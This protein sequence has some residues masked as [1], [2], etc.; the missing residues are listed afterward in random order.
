MNR[1][2]NGRSAAAALVLALGLA[3]FA[4]SAVAQD[5][6]AMR[7]VHLM[8]K[9]ATTTGEHAAVAKQ[10]R[11]QAEQLTAKAVEHEAEVTRLM[12]SA[13]PI[14]HKWPAMAPKGIQR[15]KDQAIEARR[16]SRESQRLADHHLRMSVESL[17]SR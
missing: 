3:G 13:G 15:A 11:L 1:H 4:S 2:V 12:R 17:A 9:N 7:E 5:S 10:Y 14:V 16:A 6:P 8:A